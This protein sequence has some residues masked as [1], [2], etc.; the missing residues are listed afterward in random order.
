MSFNVTCVLRS[1]PLISIWRSTCRKS[2]ILD[3]GNSKGFGGSEIGKERC[4]KKNMVCLGKTSN[5]TLW[6]TVFEIH[7]VCRV[8]MKYWFQLFLWRSMAG[9]DKSIWWSGCHQKP[10]QFQCQIWHSS[11]SIPKSPNVLKSSRY[12]N[13]PKISKLYQWKLTSPNSFSFNVRSDT[14]Y[15]I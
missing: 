14:A 2:M 1:F 3:R 8:T 6:K 7:T 15:E 13:G 12:H 11:L 9:K 4:C 10:F 5:R